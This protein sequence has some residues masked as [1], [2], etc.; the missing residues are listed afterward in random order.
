M[1][2]NIIIGLLFSMG[3][4]ACDKENTSFHMS[5]TVE[6]TNGKDTEVVINEFSGNDIVVTQNNNAV[7]IGKDSVAIND[8]GSTITGMVNGK[9]INI[10]SSGGG[11][12]ISYINGEM[13]INGKKPEVKDNENK[14]NIVIKL[15]GKQVKIPINTVE[16][17][18]ASYQVEQQCS[19]DD[20]SY[21]MV[22]EAIKP[23]LSEELNKGV[24]RL[25][26]GNYN[27]NGKPNFVLLTQP[28]EKLTVKS[29]NNVVI[30]CTSKDI[31]ILDN[32]SVTSVT[33][34]N[35]NSKEVRI[36]NMGTGKVQLEGNQIDKLI[37]TNSGVGS[38]SVSHKVNDAVLEN[39]GVGNITLSHAKLLDAEN[40][41]IGNII[42][43]KVEKVVRTRNSGIGSINY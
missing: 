16:V 8:N 37:A 6:K 33:V 4:V 42:I 28:L 39:S 41:G 12:S 23:Y 15:T 36:E 1:N 40:S 27:I 13:L 43:K 10:D 29:G 9:E 21:L 5:S 20:K 24:F 3:L 22:D 38:I 7:A 18:N 25:K 17:I 34:N 31:F 35:L 14:T 32:P 11:V 2:K 26:S 19:D 30:N